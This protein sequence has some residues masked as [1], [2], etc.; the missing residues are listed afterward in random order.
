MYSIRMLTCMNTIPYPHSRAGAVW[1]GDNTADWEHLKVSIPMLLSL[2][3]AGLQ[4]VGADIG[5]FFKNPDPELL[6]RWY[7][8]RETHW[9]L[10]VERVCTTVGCRNFPSLSLLSFHSLFL[11][12]SGFA[13]HRQV[14]SIRSCVLML[15]WTL[16][17]GSHGST[18]QTRWSSSRQPSD[19]ATSCSR[20]GTA[21]STRLTAWVCPSCARCG[22]SFPE[23]RTRGARR[24][25]SWWATVSSCD[26][27]QSKEPRPCNSTYLDPTL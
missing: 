18:T 27:S 11:S 4:F 12:P 17:G 24:T 16:G 3:V 9:S 13:T 1:T 15:T 10:L 23:T 5:G 14:R 8:V 7:Q 25:S 19:F 26:P 20:S 22:W 2:S 21:C 6:V